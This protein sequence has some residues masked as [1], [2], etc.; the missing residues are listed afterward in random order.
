[1]LVGIGIAMLLL[2]WK[3]FAR[4]LGV[5]EETFRRPNATNKR[6]VGVYQYSRWVPHIKR[7]KAV[8][9]GGMR[10]LHVFF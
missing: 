5:K 4:R 6:F 3:E 1:M 10:V 2:G 8:G 7:R 9:G